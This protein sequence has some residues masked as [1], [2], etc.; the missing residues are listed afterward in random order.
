MSLTKNVSFRK[1]GTFMGRTSLKNVRKPTKSGINWLSAPRDCPGLVFRVTEDSIVEAVEVPSRGTMTLLADVKAGA[2]V[3][4]LASS[5]DG[6]LVV[7]ACADG[8]LR[9][10]DVI[11]G[12]GMV[13]RWT[14]PNVHSHVVGTLDHSPSGNRS[15]GAAAAGPIR[16]MAFA[17][18]EPYL[19]LVDAGT[20]RLKLFDVSAK[21]PTD[22]LATVKNN[23]TGMI[24][25]C[26]AWY[27]GVRTNNI[28]L[29]VGLSNGKIVVLNFS[30]NLG[31]AEVLDTLGLP[32]ASGKK[33]QFHAVSHLDWYNGST[34]AIVA[35]G[36]NPNKKSLCTTVAVGYTA[37]KSTPS[38]DVHDPVL[39]MLTV[40]PRA[41]RSFAVKKWARM[42][43]TVPCR[44]VP[45]HGRHVFFTSFVKP[46]NDRSHYVIVATNCS[47]EV[48]LWKGTGGAWRPVRLQQGNAP[49]LKDLYPIGTTLAML[50][51]DKDDILEYAFLLMG[52]NGSMT[53]YQ[54]VNEQDDLYFTTKSSST[55]TTTTNQTAEGGGGESG[56]TQISTKSLGASL[57]NCNTR[58]HRVDT[59]PEAS[60]TEHAGQDEPSSKPSF[61]TT[62]ENKSI[63][64]LDIDDYD[65]DDD[66]AN[67][68]TILQSLLFLWLLV[69]LVV[70]VV[71]V[72]ATHYDASHMQ[73]EWRGTKSLVNRTFWSEAYRDTCRQTSRVVQ[74]V[75]VPAVVEKPST[76]WVSV[77]ATVRSSPHYQ[78]AATGLHTAVGLPLYRV[79][80]RTGESPV[81]QRLVQWG[82]QAYQSAFQLL[83]RATADMETRRV[84]DEWWSNNVDAPTLAVASTTTNRGKDR[85]PAV[86]EWLSP[87]IV[88]DYLGTWSQWSRQRLELILYRS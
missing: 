50:P 60:V 61:D 19:L 3:V 62:E 34:N 73:R 72:L 84:A 47:T 87:S 42:G 80:Q 28:P 58:F 22:L 29:L 25:T 36:S 71:V 86:S 82:N 7:V 33:L 6:K 24:A 48:V 46:S 17:R 41:A 18:Q 1:A 26:A 39:Y 55:T 30:K 38:K 16:S 57:R 88:T 63:A 67:K 10:F 52:T 75:M 20:R 12:Q 8:S 14:L 74:E 44:A 5:D 64:T 53:K 21:E 69:L 83:E 77:S 76:L 31:Q 40:K 81:G 54:L 51:R 56:P 70:L 78:S 27:P 37:V 15:F 79:Y 13:R 9:S 4:S 59:T 23:L 49:A 85:D 66:D 45:K 32:T 65:D 2:P 35:G 11:P 68:R 43:Y